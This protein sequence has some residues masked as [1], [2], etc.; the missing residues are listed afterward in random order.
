MR[1]RGG[2]DD[3]AGDQR[4]LHVLAVERIG[5]R[6]RHPRHGRLLSPGLL[7]AIGEVLGVDAEAHAGLGE[8]RR[9][10]VEHHAPLQHDRRGRGR[11]RPR[12][13]R[14]RRA[15]R[16]RRARAAGARASRGTAV[17]T[18]ASTPATG[19]SSTS[20]SGSLASAFA[21]S[22]RCCCPPDSSPIWRRRSSPSA[23]DSIA[24]A[25]ASRS[26]PWERRHQPCFARRP[27]AT[28]SSTVAGRSGAKRGRCGT[29]PR[30][31]RSRSFRGRLPE[32]LDR[33]R[34]RLEQPEHDPEQ[35][36]LRR[37]RSARRGLTNSPAPD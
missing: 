31:H 26:A 5:Q 18:A 2:A 32:Q 14:A 34:G 35:R 10:T 24:C 29:Y 8:R 19:S 36:R 9:R 1:G 21:M 20:S 17:A 33:P 6:P 27:A 16:R 13:A 15:A 12:R 7:R 22:T 4:E 30:R 28:T 3:D 25:T 37:R 23:T 11:R